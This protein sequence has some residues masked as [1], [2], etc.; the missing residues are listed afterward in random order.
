MLSIKNHRYYSIR[1]SRFKDSD[2]ALTSVI[3]TVAIIAIV[4]GFVVGPYFLIYVPENIKQN[5]SSHL[6]DVEESFLDLRGNIYTEMDRGV[7]KASVTTYLKMGTKDENLFVI[8][9]D[10]RL[11]IDP[12]ESFVS[13]HEYYDPLSIYAR[14]SGNIRYDSR[15]YYHPNRGYTFENGA[16]ITSQRQVTDISMN[17]DFIINSREEIKSVALDADFG[18]LTG[19]LNV[20]DEIYLINTHSPPVT[21]NSAR[22]SWDGGNAT[23]FQRINIAGGSVEWSGSAAS[24]ILV[25]FTSPFILNHGVYKLNLRFNADMVDSFITIELFSTTSKTI[26]DTWPNIR[27]DTIINTYDIETPGENARKFIFKNICSNPVTIKNIAVNWN[28]SAALT[29]INIAGH[30]D[31]VWSVPLPGVDSPQFLT[32]TKTSLFAPNQAGEIKLYFNGLIT[33]DQ[34]NVRIF[35]EN[36]TNLATTNYPVSLNETYVNASLSMITLVTD[37]GDSIQTTSKATKVIHTTLIS[38]EKNSYSWEQGEMLVLNIT[39]HYADA[40]YKYLND[41]LAKDNKMIWD[42]DGVGSY[43]GDYYIT[44]T[45]I[46]DELGIINLVLNSV[47]NLECVI[48]VVKVELS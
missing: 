9:G 10:G 17:P 20:L 33:E 11:V 37:N 46:T 21:L 1:N 3:V 22:I 15:N 38:A 43:P 41:T 39:T 24:G 26:A 44:L 47:T 6:K 40:W 31:D 14:G 48:G 36:S 13:I 8:G 45:E 7:S 16:I 2:D 42:Y 35:S 4:M 18:R 34:I 25:N 30:G 23:Y 28:G 32:L 12:T 5:E 29:R 27:S 19:S